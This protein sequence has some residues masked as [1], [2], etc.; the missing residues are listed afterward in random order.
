ML[1]KLICLFVAF[2]N[3]R[4]FLASKRCRKINHGTR[5]HS[6]SETKHLNCIADDED[7]PYGDLL[8][9]KRPMEVEES[10]EMLNVWSIDSSIDSGSLA[11]TRMTPKTAQEQW[12][13]WDA[14]MEQEFGNMDAEITEDQKWMIDMR[15]MV[16]QKRGMSTV[17][18]TISV[19]GHSR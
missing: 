6:S 2:H 11:K 5:F 18:T 7:D 4:S 1:F 17:L 16:E 13:H 10:Q 12:E 15:D 19:T 14:F 3:V 9:L 8:N